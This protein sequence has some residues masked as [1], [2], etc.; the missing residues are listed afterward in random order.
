M[1]SGAVGSEQ[2]ILS[3]GKQNYQR[4]VKIC[5]DIEKDGYWSQAG[6]VMKQSAQ[7]VLDLYISISAGGT[8]SASGGSV[9]SPEGISAKA[10]T[11]RSACPSR[12]SWGR[13]V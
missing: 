3:M 10:D 4:L 7:Q 8:G 5:R 2:E 13:I 12:D 11:D 1:G 9:G 6:S